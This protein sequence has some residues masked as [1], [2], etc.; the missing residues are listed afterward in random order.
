MDNT[1]QKCI[2]C[3]E[4]NASCCTFQASLDEKLGPRGRALMQKREILDTSFYDCTLC[5]ACDATCPYDVKQ[6]LRKLR[7]K[8]VDAGITTKANRRMLTNLKKF[9]TPYGEDKTLY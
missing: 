4:C 5:G 9:G 8:M 2:T 7:K 3:G 6:G 1:A